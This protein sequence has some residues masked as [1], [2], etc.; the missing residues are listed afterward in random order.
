MSLLDSRPTTRRH[1]LVRT[2]SLG[3]L[4][5]AAAAFA[6]ASPAP[7]AAQTTVTLTGRVTAQGRPVGEA[8]FGVEAAG[9]KKV[10]AGTSS[11]D[12]V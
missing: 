11:A 9:Y 1:R 10:G 4:L 7:L 3:A 8:Q 5:A 2:T 12:A 6:L